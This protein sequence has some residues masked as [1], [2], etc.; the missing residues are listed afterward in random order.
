MKLK[1]QLSRLLLTIFSL[2]GAWSGQALCQTSGFVEDSQ[3]RTTIRE[4]TDNQGNREYQ[5]QEG[6]V[7][8]RQGERR[9]GEIYEDDRDRVAS[10]VRSLKL[11]SISIGPAIASGINNNN[12]FYAFG[13]DR[14]WDVQ[15]QA[16]MRVSA[17][18]V[19]PSRETGSFLMASLGG[20]YFFSRNDI[21]PVIGADLGFGTAV[22][23]DVKRASGFAGGLRAGLRFFRTSETQ[24]SI[25]GYYRTVFAEQTP[26]VAGLAIAAHF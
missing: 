13:V 1:I 17:F 6:R 9:V 7:K 14:N 24:I 16:E 23:T 2:V 11:W 3:K 12:M 26:G 22:G 21:S 8:P 5:I 19:V 18:G 20:S 4:G 15:E 25:E 10:R